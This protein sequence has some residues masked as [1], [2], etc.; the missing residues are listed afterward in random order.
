MK[1]PLAGF[2]GS[3]CYDLSRGELTVIQVWAERRQILG[4]MFEWA[5]KLGCRYFLGSKARPTWANQS[6]ARALNAD[7]LDDLIRPVTLTA[8]EVE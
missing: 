2:D 5:L 1:R 6:H 4:E 7:Q 8:G 3:I